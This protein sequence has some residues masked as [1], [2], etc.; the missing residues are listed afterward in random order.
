MVRDHLFLRGIYPGQQA[1]CH[2]FCHLFHFCRL[3]IQLTTA[4][5][6]PTSTSIDQSVQSH[7]WHHLSVLGWISLVFTDHFN[8]HLIITLNYNTINE[9]HIL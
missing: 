6:S 9:L 3:M 1:F 7:F 4:I 2:L 8:T 5:C